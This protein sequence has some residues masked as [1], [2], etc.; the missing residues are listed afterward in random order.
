VNYAAP[1]VYRSVERLLEERVRPAIQFRG[2]S[3]EL[4][5]IIDG[6]MIVT[7]TGACSGFRTRRGIVH[8]G[9]LGLVREQVPQV[10]GIREKFDFEDF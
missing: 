7:V 5:E 8:N 2:G 3:I 1:E 6:V 10:T 9:V 4:H